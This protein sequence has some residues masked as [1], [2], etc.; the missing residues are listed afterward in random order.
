M[1]KTDYLSYFFYQATDSRIN[2]AIAAL[3]GLV[4][5]LVNQ[6][7]LLV[8]YIRKKHDH[9]GKALFEDANAW[10]V[11]SEILTNIIG[12]ELKQHVSNY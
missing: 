7:L 11:L 6:Q 8:L 3:R 1:A 5:L 12:P 10:V 4:Y 2:N 9:A